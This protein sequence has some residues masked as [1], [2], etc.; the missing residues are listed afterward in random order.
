MGGGEGSL[1]IGEV[2][3]EVLEDVDALEEDG[4]FEV[5]VVV[6]EENRGVAHRGEAWEEDEEAHEV[7]SSESANRSKAHC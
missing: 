6:V 2:L 7:K 4:G 5:L 3:N 1:A